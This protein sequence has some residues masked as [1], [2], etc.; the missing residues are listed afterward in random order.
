MNSVPENKTMISVNFHAVDTAIEK[1]F[2]ELSKKMTTQ[3]KDCNGND[4]KIQAAIESSLWYVK[5]EVIQSLME[6]A[7]QE[8]SDESEKPVTKLVEPAKTQPKPVEPIVEQPM[9]DECEPNVEE[10]L[11]KKQLKEQS[12]MQKIRNLDFPL[13]F[14]MNLV[15][16]N[17]CQGLKLNHSLYTQCT[18]KPR[19]N[20]T[21]C[22]TCL[23]Q[24]AA[25]ENKMPNAGSIQS[26]IEYENPMDFKDPKDKRPVHYTKIL[27]K[28]KFNKEDI[29]AK[30]AEVGIVI[31]ECHLICS[32]P[33]KRGRRVK[34]NNIVSEEDILSE[35][36]K[37]ESVEK[38][39]KEPELVKEHVE[40]NEKEEIEKK[41]EPVNE[42]EA[43]EGKEN[44]SDKVD[45]I[46][47]KDKDCVTSDETE[48]YEITYNDTLYLKTEDG[49]ILD[50]DT[51][52]VVGKY[53]KIT[54]S[55]TFH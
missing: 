51:E 36:E 44:E 46:H 26:R 24:I 41:E 1:R 43:I 3:I 15:D 4:D 47:E 53:N 27:T 33:P 31:D 48:V 13:P 14:Q 16:H 37:K 45:E 35:E 12:I 22:N 11:A 2:S 20:Q 8:T 49:D 39:E 23:K 40:E 9:E 32:E 29:I 38:N 25:N 34:K 42:K 6:M 52:E 18:T 5:Q 17:A 10:K 7:K 28:L 55:I 54:E 50:I 19:K 21:Y 30:A